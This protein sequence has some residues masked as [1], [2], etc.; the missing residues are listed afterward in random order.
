MGKVEINH[1]QLKYQE[2]GNCLE[3]NCTIKPQ[4]LLVCALWLFSGHY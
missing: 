3:E 1:Q 2:T 4:L